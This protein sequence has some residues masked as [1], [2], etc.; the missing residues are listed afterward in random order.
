MKSVWACT[1]CGALF[2]HLPHREENNEDCRHCG[3]SVEPAGVLLEALDVAAVVAAEGDKILAEC[4]RA[5][6]IL[7]GR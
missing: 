5:L 3:S 1:F 4:A 6:D 7:E 2:L